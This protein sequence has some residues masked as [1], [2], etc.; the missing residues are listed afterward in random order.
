VF[1]ESDDTV[2]K[3]PVAVI[4]Y[5]YWQKRFAGDKSVVNRVVSM[6]G[7]MVTI[8]GVMPKEYIGHQKLG[9]DAP[10]ITVPLAFDAVFSP[11][12]A[13]PNAPAP[14]PRMSQPT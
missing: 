5:L 9:N 11:P 1:D 6:N 3:P 7:Q 2:T 8:V 14:V 10:E 4:S 13:L 12:Q